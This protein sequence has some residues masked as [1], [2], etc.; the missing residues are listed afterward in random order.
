MRK[1]KIVATVLLLCLF[2]AL[3]LSGGCNS[4][5]GEPSGGEG[6]TITFTDSA[7]REVEIPAEIDRIVPSGTMAQMVLFSLAPDKLVGL[8]AKWSSAAGEYLDGKYQ[9]LPVL[10]QFYGGKGD[11]NLEE[12][13]RVSPQ[14]IIDIGEPKSSIVEDMDLITEQVGIPAVHLTATLETMGDAYR[15]LGKLVGMEDEAAVLADYCDELYRKTKTLADN[16][17]DDKTSL[18]YCSGDDGLNVIARGS[19][20]AELVDLLGNNVAVVENATSKG[21]GNLVDLE[22]LVLWDPAVI[23][24]APDS[25]YSSV[26]DDKAWQEIAAI[27]EGCYYEVPANPHNWMGFPPSVNRY[28]GMVWLAQ[29]LYPE[30]A[31]YDMFAEISKYYELFYHCAL[32][33]EQFNDLLAN[34]LLKDS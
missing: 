33:E 14:L 18:L 15:E 3:L 29:L 10:G 23:I 30:E 12:I 11:L 6:E 25:I 20:H 9:N 5:S 16:I 32:T 27:R 21:T 24:F 26:A 22:Q 1:N 28:L 17:G 19:F 13:A 31:G 8:A 7:G 34:S 4:D 2:L